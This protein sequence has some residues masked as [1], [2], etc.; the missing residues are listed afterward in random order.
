MID[1]TIDRLRAAGCIAAEEEAAELHEAA[2]GDAARL[3]ELVVRRCT[4]EPIA[5]L[6]GWVEFCGLRLAVHPGVY[7]PRPHTEG[8]ALEAAARLPVDGIGV[9]LCAGCGPLAAVMAAARPGARVLATD[10]D[11]RAVACAAANGLE[12]VAG[13]LTAGLPDGLAGRVDVV[14][15]VVPYVPTRELALLPRDVTAFEPRQALDGG[16]DGTDLLV[17]AIRAS[18]RLLRPGGSLLLELGGDEGALLTAELGAAGFGD[19]QVVTD[20]D[21]DLAVYARLAPSGELR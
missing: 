3:Q 8:L 14:A 17:R 5:W 11:E 9:E 1:E 16:A 18:A 15:A 2:D 19:V 4:G 20:E 10:V 13:D 12:A 7:V 6:T 21:R